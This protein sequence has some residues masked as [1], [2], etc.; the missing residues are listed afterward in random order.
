MTLNLKE[1]LE[2]HVS[3]SLEAAKQYKRPTLP[4]K[5]FSPVSLNSWLYFALAAKIDYVS[6]EMVGN[7]NTEALLRFET[8]ELSKD[9]MQSLF[10]INENLDDQHMLRWDCCAPSGVKYAMATGQGMESV[11]LEDKHLHPGDPRAFDILFEYPIEEVAIFKRP[12]VKPLL[13]NGYPV[14]FRV[15]VING[16]IKAASNYYPQMTLPYTHENLD[17]AKQAIE[18][19]QKLLTAINQSG[20]QLFHAGEI[21]DTLNLTMDFMVVEDG[22]VQFLEGGPGFGFGAHPCCFHN[23]TTKAVEPLNGLLLGE[24]ERS[25]DIKQWLSD[26]HVRSLKV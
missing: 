6:A 13:S 18:S 22:S 11:P 23:T 12:I 17:Y 1:I 2:R 10:A 3:E 14:E 15:F 9:A 16:E 7:I 20:V 25:I 21:A 8:P 5:A 19:A 26:S 24:G 4:D